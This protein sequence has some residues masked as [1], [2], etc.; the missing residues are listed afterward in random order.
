MKFDLHCHTTASDG[1]LEP[2]ALLQLAL[3]RNISHIAI[4]DHD[5]IAAYDQLE[6][7]PGITVIPGVEFSSQ[8]CRRGIHIVG[9]NFDPASAAIRQG[10]ARHRK[11]RRERAE[12]IASR[13]AKA[14]VPNP[15]EGAIAQAGGDHNLGRP[16]FARHMVA[17]GFVG[18]ESEAFKRYLGNGKVGD[19]RECWAGPEEVVAWIRAAGGTAVLAHPEKYQLTRTRLTALL[20][21]FRQWGG[22]GLEVV[23][24]RQLPR[25]TADLAHWCNRYEL[26]ASWGSDFHRPGQPWSDLGNYST[27]PANLSTVWQG[28]FEGC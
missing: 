5:T 25:V 28:W 26:R 2:R 15:F 18:D 23:S 13:L 21:A 12:K 9:L 4:T 6:V 20:T 8:W 1:A 19:I 3:E 10:V 11:A 14:G 17:C 22:E 16:H 24:G 7:P 27:P